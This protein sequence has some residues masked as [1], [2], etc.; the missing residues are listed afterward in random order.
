V[1]PP[2]PMCCLIYTCRSVCSIVLFHNSPTI[3]PAKDAFRVKQIFIMS[4]DTEEATKESARKVVTEGLTDPDTIRLLSAAGDAAKR[5]RPNSPL[6]RSRL[7]QVHID[8][9]NKS[10][11]FDLT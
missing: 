1:Y 5:S 4:K 7:Q 10:E 9:W 6:P 3:R 11:F 2:S 8:S